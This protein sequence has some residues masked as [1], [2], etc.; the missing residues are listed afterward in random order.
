MNLNQIA[1]AKSPLQKCFFSGFHQIH[2][3]PTHLPTDHQPLTYQ[4]TDYQLN[5]SLNQ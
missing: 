5:D 1:Q 2:G 3:P 4:P